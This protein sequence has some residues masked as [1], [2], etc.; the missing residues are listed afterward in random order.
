MVRFSPFIYHFCISEFRLA[1]I[2][3]TFLYRRYT[4][5]IT[6]CIATVLLQGEIT[7][8]VECLMKYDL[9]LGISIPK[10]ISPEVASVNTD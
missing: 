10:N 7:V 4:L 1:V 5:P 8:S 3:P 9:K 6:I 2:Q